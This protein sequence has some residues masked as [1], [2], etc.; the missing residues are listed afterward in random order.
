MTTGA[1][2]LVSGARVTVAGDRAVVVREGM[3]AGATGRVTTGVRGAAADGAA[4]RVWIGVVRL[5]SGARVAAM[6]D[7]MTGARGVASDGVAGRICTGVLRLVLGVRGATAG[8]DWTIGARGVTVEGAAGRVT[9]GAV[10][11]CGAG[12][13]PGALAG[14]D[15]VTV[16]RDTVGRTGCGDAGRVTVGCGALTRGADWTRGAD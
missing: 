7:W 6:G 15:G 12:A 14:R 10:R 9:A 13:A 16:G 1:L 11:V 2:R 8:D 3:V 4:G 5:V